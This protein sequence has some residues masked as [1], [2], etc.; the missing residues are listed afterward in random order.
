MK[1]LIMGLIVL[2]DNGIELDNK[3]LDL[4]DKFKDTL[5]DD[6]HTVVFADCSTL[7]DSLTD[8]AREVSQGHAVSMIIKFAFPAGIFNP[9]LIDVIRKILTDQ[10]QIRMGL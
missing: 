4:V 3:D 6:D 2:G 1:F 10:R 5:G 9:T 7:Q 8:N